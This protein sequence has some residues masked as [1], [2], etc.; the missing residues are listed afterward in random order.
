MADK[1]VKIDCYIIRAKVRGVWLSWVFL[2]KLNPSEITEKEI[3]KGIEAFLRDAVF[4]IDAFLRDA[5]FTIDVIDEIMVEKKTLEVK[6]LGGSDN[7]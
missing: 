3:C 6:T 1:E 2:C 5:V 7:G 4:T